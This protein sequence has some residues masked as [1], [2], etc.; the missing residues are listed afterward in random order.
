ML[1]EA[2]AQIGEGGRIVIPANYRRMLHLEVGQEV[3]L[4]LS[5]D[6]IRISPLQA[7]V[8]RAQAAVRKYNANQDKLSDE[9]I[10]MRREENNGL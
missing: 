3:I 6:E 2:R 5:N 7:A 4:S 8:K 10:T 1:M 9:L